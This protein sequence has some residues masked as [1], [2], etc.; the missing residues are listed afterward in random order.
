MTLD[1]YERRRTQV[2]LD[3]LRAAQP[4]TPLALTLPELCALVHLQGAQLDAMQEVITALEKRLTAYTVHRHGVPHQLGHP[5]TVR[6]STAQVWTADLADEPD[7][8]ERL[9]AEASA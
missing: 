8:F 5:Y 1:E 3:Q 7:A 2:A 9:S 4:V 6:T